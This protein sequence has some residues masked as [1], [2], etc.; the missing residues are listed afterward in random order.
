MAEDLQVSRGTLVWAFTIRQIVGGV[1]APLLG[2]AVDRYG[3]RM[4]GIWG[5][6]TVGVTLIGT[7][8]VS[9]IWVLYTLFAISGL[10]GFGTFCG[11]LLIMVPVTNWF[12]AKRGRAVAVASTGSLL[13][14]ASLTL[15]AVFLIEN[16]GWRWAST[17]FGI[18]VL[19]TILPAYALFMKRHPE[20]IGLLP[21]GASSRS[22]TAPSVTGLTKPEPTERHWTL[23]EAIQTPVLWQ[24]VICMA[25]IQFAV[26]GILLFRTSFWI[27]QGI[28]PRVVAI[29]VAADPLT[30]FVTVFIF[31]FLAD[32]MSIRW[33][34]LIGGVWRGISILPL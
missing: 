34:G 16:V 13:D 12:V 28:A 21:D 25:L 8:F 31:G 18:V 6:L 20:D 3:S 26:G 22:A 23:K 30:V 32:R 33:I 15:V 5:G 27:D 9:N 4:P 7:A 29:G 1:A 24:I 17:I 14:T 11:N 2:R 19:V 10:A